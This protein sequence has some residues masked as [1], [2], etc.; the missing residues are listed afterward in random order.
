MDGILA[1]PSLFK[2]AKAEI[3]ITI[4]EKKTLKWSSPDLFNDPFEYKSPL[5]YGF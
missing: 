2:Y 3:A 5:E 4:L 1:I